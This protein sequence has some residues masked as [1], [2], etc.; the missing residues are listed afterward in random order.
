M[1]DFDQAMLKEL[2]AFDELISLR[3]QALIDGGMFVQDDEGHSSV[4]HVA[5]GRMFA[6]GAIDN[7]LYRIRR[8]ITHGNADGY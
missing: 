6:L 2:D 4:N 7:A 1:N 5:M 8:R 3:R